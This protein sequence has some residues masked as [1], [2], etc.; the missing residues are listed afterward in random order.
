MLVIVERYRLCSLYLA[1]ET[2]LPSSDLYSV[3]FASI[4]EPNGTIMAT[5]AKAAFT[6]V[7]RNPP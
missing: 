4:Q 3:A 1:L 5:F 2:F 7:L 6:K